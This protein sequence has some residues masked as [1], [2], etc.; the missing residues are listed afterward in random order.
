M[1]Y[2]HNGN[3]DGDDNDETSDKLTN[4]KTLGVDGFK[5]LAAISFVAWAT[6]MVIT[7]RYNIRDEFEAR[8]KQNTEDIR[9][10]DQ[11][12]HDV[13]LKDHDGMKAE[14]RMLHERLEVLE[15]ST[16]GVLK[17]QNDII[18]R[19]KEVLAKIRERQLYVLEN[20]WTR[21]D[22]NNWCREVQLKNPNWTCPL[23]ES[24]DRKRFLLNPEQTGVNNTLSQDLQRALEEDPNMLWQ[25]PETKHPANRK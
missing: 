1:N 11:M 14:M 20:I 2:R 18:S 13:L 12:D 10:L 17:Q 9:R 25:T 23:Y 19:I 22:H 8:I 7:E 5:F 21:E 3:D 4:V 15:E 16:Q 6:W 24:A